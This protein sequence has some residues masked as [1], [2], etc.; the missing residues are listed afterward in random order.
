[1]D[2]NLANLWALVSFGSYFLALLTIPSVLLRRRGRPIAAL[3][4][5]LGLFAFPFFGLVGWWI[6]GRRHLDRHRKRRQKSTYQIQSALASLRATIKD[7]PKA[8]DALLLFRQLPEHLRDCVFHPTA[9]N[10]VELLI[11]A[12]QAYPPMK[13]AIREAQEFIH[14][15]F[16]MWQN[17][18]VGREFRDL[19]VFRARAGVK[20]RVL[21]DSVGSSY[22][23]HHFLA[24]LEEAGVEVSYVPAKIFQGHPTVNFR[25]HRKILIVDGIVAYGGG[26]NIGC[27][28]TSNWRDIGLKMEGPVVDQYQEVFVDDWY[29][30][31][32][33]NITERC[34]FGRWQEFWDGRL[35]P[36]Q[37][38]ADCAVIASGPHLETKILRDAFFVAM[39]SARKRIWLITPY[40]IP[41]KAIMVALQ[42][43]VFRGVD[44]RIL[45]PGLSDVPVVKFAAR[46]YYE[47]LIKAGV[48]I[49]EYQRAV[50]HAKALLFDDELSIVGSANLDIRSFRLNFEVTSLIASKAFNEQLA[51][52]FRGDCAQ[53]R[54]VTMDDLENRSYVKQLLEAFAH[55][56]SPLL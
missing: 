9:G 11:D 17:D 5:V 15:L 47:D 52:H 13:Q 23:D 49:F 37:H 38:V 12:A 14:F 45:V 8:D 2:L 29:F 33:E 43:A 48:R 30:A 27:D 41:D 4:W 34:Y 16:Y 19:L 28:Y 36:G 31:T 3:S 7:A 6:L 35:E 25:N 10:R 53:A 32:G 21:V 42:T 50:L 54:E 56:M 26:L 40:F 18:A 46:S 39:T 20:V 51:Q 24:P 1:M 55:L 44:V 22:L